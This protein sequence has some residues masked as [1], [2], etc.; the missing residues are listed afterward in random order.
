MSGRDSLLRFVD[1]R[2]LVSLLIMGLFAWAYGENV[3]DETMKGAIIAA[4][5]GAWGFWIGSARA[6]ERDEQATKN[7]AAAFEA[8][9]ATAQAGTGE[10]REQ[11][12]ADGTP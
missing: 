5:A 12:A 11:R 1:P 4:F 8:I 10:A 6:S 2:L 9:K 3:S 7:T